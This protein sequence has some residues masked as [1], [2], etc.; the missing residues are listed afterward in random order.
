MQEITIQPARSRA[1]L[2]DVARYVPLIRVI[3]LRDL[4]ARYKQSLLGPIWIVIQPLTLLGAYM[5]GFRGV[6]H[7]ATGHVPYAVFALA[8]IS[9]WA[10]FQAATVAGTSAF[11]SNGALVAQTTCPRVV[12]PLAALLSCLPSLLIPLVAGLISAAFVGAFSLRW[13]LLPFL[14]TWVLLLTAGIV[15]ITS[16]VTVRFRDM[17]QVMP[18]LLQLGA[19]VVPVGYPAETLSPALRVIVSLNPLTGIIE[20][21]RWAMLDG[22]HPYVLSV[23]LSAG[24]GAI[25]VAI[26]WRVFAHTEVI[27]A[28]VL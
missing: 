20:L 5:V 19:F 4:K 2:L 10:Y 23:Y 1:R 13:L 26:G 17:V 7:I 3:S 11:I 8:G 18:F 24:I 28:D 21:W 22:S 27:M 14:A 25:V 16:S 9:I 6:T 12:L 15:W